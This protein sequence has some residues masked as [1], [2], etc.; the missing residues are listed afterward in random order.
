MNVR[1]KV[2]VRVRVIRSGGALKKSSLRLIFFKRGLALPVRYKS[3]I[4]VVDVDDHLCS[5]VKRVGPASSWSHD[6]AS[7][8]RSA[9]RRASHP[10]AV[11]DE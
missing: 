3:F 1:V 4:R 8:G 11:H 9:E 2:R 10:A 6:P 5:L 7:C